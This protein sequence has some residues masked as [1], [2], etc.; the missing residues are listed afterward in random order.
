MFNH[1]RFAWTGGVFP[2]ESYFM[3]KRPLFQSN[4]L[5]SS[6]SLIAHLRTHRQSPRL[7]WKLWRLPSSR[8]GLHCKSILIVSCKT[9]KITSSVS[10]VISCTLG[11]PA[12]NCLFTSSFSIKRG[13]EPVFATFL[14]FL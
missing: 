13:F 11:T 12:A 2:Y 14:I 7:C 5:I 10:H 3:K 9:G 6:L 4:G 8:L 1:K